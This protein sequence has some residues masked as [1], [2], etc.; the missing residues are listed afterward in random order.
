MALRLEDKKVI[1]EEVAGIASGAASL[2]VADYRGLTVA[3]MTEL[4]AKARAGN[5]Y[6]RVVRN[7]LARR[8][9]ESTEFECVKS[10]LIGPMILAFSLND[11]PSAAARLVR[12]F[13]KDHDKLKAKVVAIGGKVIPAAQLSV[14]ANLPTYDEAISKLMGVMKAPLEKFV[15]TLAAPHTKFVRTMDAVREQKQAA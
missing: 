6:L 9:V 14:V 12:D 5:V 2:V 15:G 1:V 10:D 13:A 3:E 11:E 7:T 4:R 8:A